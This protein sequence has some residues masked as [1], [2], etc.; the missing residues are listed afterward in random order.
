MFVWRIQN[1]GCFVTVLLS[2][3]LT[4]RRVWQ[5]KTP[6]EH[7][8]GGKKVMSTARLKMV[9]FSIISYNC[10]LLYGVTEGKGCCTKSIK[11]VHRVRACIEMSLSTA[12]AD[13]KRASRR[14]RPCETTKGKTRFKAVTSFVKRIYHYYYYYYYNFCLIWLIRKLSSIYQLIS[15]IL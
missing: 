11:R 14:E 3:I 2:F 15:S 1:Y 10:I 13:G 12:S 5:G 8:R 4:Q 7:M 9:I 6:W